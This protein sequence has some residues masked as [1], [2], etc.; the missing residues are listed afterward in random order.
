MELWLLRLPDQKRFRLMLNS[1]APLNPAV[2]DTALHV[3]SE[4]NKLFSRHTFR[5]FHMIQRGELGI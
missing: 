5:V 1:T 4:L 2:S 3:I